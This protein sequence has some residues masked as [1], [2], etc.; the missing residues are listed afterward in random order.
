[1]KPILFIALTLVTHSLRAQLTNCIE[2]ARVQATYQCN[3]SFYDPVC[4]CDNKTYRNQCNAYNNHGVNLW[5][6]GVCNGFDVDFYPNPVSN[7]TPL[8]INMSHN[9][10]VTGNAT[11]YIVDMYGKIWDQRFVNNFNRMQI[12]FDI[13]TLRTGLYV[14]VVTSSINV[15]I[16]RMFAKY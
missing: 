2:P 14:L 11:V 6:T 8:T 15:T 7:S 10:F 1:M 4:G 13:S 16:T 5:R 12:Q 9:E 3:L